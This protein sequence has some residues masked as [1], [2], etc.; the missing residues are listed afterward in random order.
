MFLGIVLAKKYIM[1][2]AVGGV[3]A[4]M[5]EIVYFLLPFIVIIGTYEDADLAA[6]QPKIENYI[7]GAIIYWVLLI[8]F[9]KWGEPNEPNP[10]QTEELKPDNASKQKG[11]GKNCPSCDNGYI[12]PWNGQERC[13]SCVQVFGMASPN[14]SPNAV[15]TVELKKRPYIVDSR[16]YTYI[17]RLMVACLNSRSKPTYYS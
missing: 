8:L 14:T 12:R 13:W 9:L 3:A 5:W 15:S 11:V 2:L 16:K 10:R 1:E 17:F 6:D 7:V 4:K